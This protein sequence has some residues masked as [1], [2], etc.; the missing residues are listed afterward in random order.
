MPSSSSEDDDRITCA[1]CARTTEDRR[2]TLYC[3]AW[4]EVDGNGVKRHPPTIRDLPRRCFFFKAQRGAPDQ[5][6]GIERWPCT[7]AEYRTAHR[8]KV[9]V[10]WAWM[11][12]V[13]T[14]KK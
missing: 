3:T 1:S 11:D 8:R 2:G 13:D 10:W 5:R 4:Q 12:P 7:E 9:G 6:K 14:K